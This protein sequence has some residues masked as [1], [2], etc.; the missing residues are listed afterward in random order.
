M[1]TILSILFLVLSASA[2]AQDLPRAEDVPG[3]V[4]VVT[5]GAAM[6]GAAAPRAE[7]RDLRVMVVREDD[8][9]KAVVGLPLKLAP[10]VYKVT[11]SFADG[12]T[13]G[14]PFRVV[15]K[16]YPT[17]YITLKNKHQ[18]DLTKADLE[19]YYRDVKEIDRAK[20]TWSN[21]AAPPLHLELPV[22]G[23]WISSEFGLRRFFNKEARSPHGGLDLAV[24][25]GT[26][27]R[28]P[29]AGVVLET[30]NFFFTGNTIFLDH[31]Q[32][33]ITMYCHLSR[34]NVKPG[35]HVRRGQLIAESGA[36]GRITGPHLHWSVILNRDL[37]D[38]AA[39]I[40][41]EALASLPT[42]RPSA[43]PS[44]DKGS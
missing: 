16:D 40:S 39:F 28:A 9:W 23:G 8:A 41:R 7:F 6:D 29:A 1:R 32:G 33:L 34:F 37:V 26:P 10:G 13:Q 36:T 25:V 12:R 42:H 5:L 24:P 38:P 15:S 43:D 4:A 2:A 22:H 31:G 3:G 17:Q 20:S 35:D 18:V 14:Y 11:A 19:R 27:V 44:V 30:E 21:V